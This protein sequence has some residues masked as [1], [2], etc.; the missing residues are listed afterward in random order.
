MIES[1][2]LKAMME[3]TCSLFFTLFGSTSA[4][5][6]VI[7]LWEVLMLSV[8]LLYMQNLR[9]YSRTTDNTFSSESGKHWTR[10]FKCFH[11]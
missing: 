10:S 4:T 11:W 6:S 8:S 1:L 5:L 9:P 3:N 7:H 2:V